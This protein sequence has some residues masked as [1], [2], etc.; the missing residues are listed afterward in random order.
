MFSHVVHLKVGKSRSFKFSSQG[1]KSLFVGLF[2][3]EN[4]QDKLFTCEE[5]SLIGLR[6]V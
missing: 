2:F 3:K 4:L 1:E 6:W 5:R